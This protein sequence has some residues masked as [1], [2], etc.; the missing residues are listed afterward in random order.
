MYLFSGAIMRNR[1]LLMAVLAVVILIIGVMPAFA[2]RSAR[3]G[4]RNHWLSGRRF[5]LHAAVYS[6]PQGS[7]ETGP[8]GNT[9]NVEMWD[10]GNL[11]NTQKRDAAGVEEYVTVYFPITP[12]F[13]RR[14]MS[15][16]TS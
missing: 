2:G 5:V 11:L 6:R 14:K 7:G 15:V 3:G 9:V 13:M 1:V 12:A 10:D 4:C 16:S 8:G